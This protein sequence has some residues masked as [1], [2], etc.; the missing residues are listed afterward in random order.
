MY[1]LD[2][3]GVDFVNFKKESLTLCYIFLFTYVN[4]IS[5]LSLREYSLLGCHGDIEFDL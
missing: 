1:K 2:A 3:D 4:L 5:I